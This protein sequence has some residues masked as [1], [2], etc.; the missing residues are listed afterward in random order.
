M[1]RENPDSRVDVQLGVGTLELPHR[2]LV[3][4]I[5]DDCILGFDFLKKHSCEVDLSKDVLTIHIQQVPLQR[6]TL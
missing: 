3:A 6:P 4:D 2:M 5:K 1:T